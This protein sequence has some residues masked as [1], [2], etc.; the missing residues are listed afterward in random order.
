MQSR[1]GPRKGLAPIACMS[2]FAAALAFATVASNC[3]LVSP[4]SDLPRCACGAGFAPLSVNGQHT[5]VACE[6]GKYKGWVSYSWQKDNQCHSCDNATCTKGSVANL[7]FTSLHKC[8]ST[9][10]AYCDCTESLAKLKSSQVCTAQ[11]WN[12]EQCSGLAACCSYENS[13]CAP[14][15]GMEGKPCCELPPKRRASAP[16]EPKANR[17]STANDDFN[18]TMTVLSMMGPLLLVAVV[19]AALAG[20][21]SLYVAYVTWVQHKLVIA[22]DKL[23]PAGVNQNPIWNESRYVDPSILP[24]REP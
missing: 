13:R 22:A 3:Y 17:R 7:T 23:Q 4:S 6:A 5:C 9:M 18:N 12:S 24:G 8:T 10:N 2:L 20:P 15:Q 11:K 19:P 21:L 1:G 14:Y 16:L